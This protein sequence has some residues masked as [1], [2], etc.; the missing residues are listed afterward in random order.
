MEENDG[1]D[2]KLVHEILDNFKIL[3]N[4]SD[5]SKDDM[6]EILVRGICTNILIKTNRR[7]FPEK[8]KHVAIN[9]VNDAYLASKN[10]ADLQSVQSMS[11]FDRTVNFGLADNVKTKLNLIAQK[12]VED[13]EKLI[14]RFRLLYKT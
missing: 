3:A 2:E 9:I 14:N 11:E 7:T 8:L 1:I 12:Q 6:L 5:N 10:D 13:N 4:I